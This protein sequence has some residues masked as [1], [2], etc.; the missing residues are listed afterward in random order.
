MRRCD[1]TKIVSLRIAIG[2]LALAA[3]NPLCGEDFRYVDLAAGGQSAGGS[4]GSGG[5][6]AG[7][8][9]GGG[10]A[11]P[12]CVH[13]WSAGYGDGNPD[14]VRAVARA[15]GADG[16]VAIG[17]TYQ[18]DL[19]LGA[20]LPNSPNLDGFVASL[21]ATTG[22]PNWV[23]PLDGDGQV[24][25]SSMAVDVD[26]RI[27]ASG[28]YDGFLV[29][30][31][32]PF[33]SQGPFDAFFLVAMPGGS[34]E[35]FVPLSGTG[36]VEVDDSTMRDG[37][38]YLSGD[39]GGVVNFGGSELTSNGPD[40]LFVAR[41]SGATLDWVRTYG[42]AGSEV[43]STLAATPGGDVVVAGEVSGD[44]D[45]GTGM[46]PA[47]GG[48]DLFVAR[49]S[50]VTK[51][52]LWAARFGD[53][54]AQAV[55]DVVVDEDGDVLLCGTI[56]G[57]FDLFGLGAITALGNDA[58]VAKLDG[59]TG[60]AVWAQR[61]GGADDQAA[62]RLAVAPDGAILVTGR[63][64]GTIDFGGGELQSNGA[65]N[66][67]LVEFDGDGNH[68]WSKAFGTGDNTFR[69]RIAVGDDGAIALSGSFSNAVDF[70]GG[71][72]ATQGSTD[73]FTAMLDR[74]D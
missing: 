6:G 62:Q 33:V 44:I 74:T 59:L 11:G 53:S 10:G 50:D 18:G 19:A 56:A 2:C 42:N 31:N 46:L 60:E 45:L 55:H 48:T 65:G 1:T 40:N 7:G 41:F 12:G 70:G 73:I 14:G 27:L 37:A 52:T 57:A 20:P 21:D 58:F 38:V 30:D 68:R 5:S 54:A 9:V 64:T 71:P 3:C 25:V 26:G 23:L 49:L 24:V 69:G 43:A 34:V 32:S 4:G 22:T 63:F 72:L 67:F 66:G 35:Q 36:A 28:V 13:R 8:D 39:F 16:F 47:F 17:G 15:P 61:Y 51:D 29:V